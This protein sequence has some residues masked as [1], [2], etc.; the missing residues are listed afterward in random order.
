MR[1]NEVGDPELWGK[2]SYEE[3]FKRILLDIGLSRL[4]EEVRMDIRP[5]EPLF[6]LS[7]RVR[8]ATGM[9]RVQDVAKIEERSGGTMLTITNELYAP[10]LLALLWRIFGRDYVDQLSR[11]EIMVRGVTADELREIDLDP[12]EELKRKVLDAVWRLLP[13]GFKVRHNLYGNWVLTVAA[14][15]HEMAAEWKERAARMHRE[16]GGN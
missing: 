11:F 12:E 10:R 14:T 3:L 13:E 7:I 6:L 4:V 5:E 1:M 9:V 15:E 8:P 2:R 16:M